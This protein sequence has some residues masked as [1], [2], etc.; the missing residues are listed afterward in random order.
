MVGLN[1]FTDKE[2]RKARRSFQ[3]DRIHADL[4]SPKYRE[5]TIPNRKKNNGPYYE[6]SYEE[7]DDLG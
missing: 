4:R 6:E 1:K 2:R 7:Y 5:R 3:S